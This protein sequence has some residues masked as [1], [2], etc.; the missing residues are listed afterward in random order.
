MNEMMIIKNWLKY[1]IRDCRWTHRMDDVMAVPVDLRLQKRKWRKER[2]LFVILQLTKYRTTECN[3]CFLS[4]VYLLYFF[5]S[6]SLV[7]NNQTSSRRE[8]SN[9]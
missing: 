2:S 7:I 8:S 1:G 9:A 5:A 6:A 4:A 3:M